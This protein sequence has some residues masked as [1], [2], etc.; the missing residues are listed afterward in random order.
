MTLER[1][2]WRE[3]AT[4]KPDVNTQVLVAA[5][6]FEVDDDYE[7]TETITGWTQFTSSMDAHGLFDEPEFNLIDAG[8]LNSAEAYGE[9]LFWMPLPPDPATPSDK[10]GDGDA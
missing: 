7:P 2:V 8:W 5:P 6:I 4:D 3:I 1:E 9:P 10:A